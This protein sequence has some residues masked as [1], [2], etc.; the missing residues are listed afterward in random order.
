MDYNLGKEGKLGSR[1]G[2]SLVSRTGKFFQGLPF[3]QFLEIFSNS[4][5]F[6]E[7]L[8]PG[9]FNGLRT[10]GG[11]HPKFNGITFPRFATAQD[12]NPGREP[13]FCS[14]FIWRFW[15]GHISPFFPRELNPTDFRRFSHSWELGL[16]YSLKAPLLK[17]DD[18]L[19]KITL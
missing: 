10:F 19:G 18:T 8:A 6:R 7:E 1:K 16:I 5:L 11:A 13:L 2:F 4:G 12:G 3:N 17:I 14:K 9:V 15:A